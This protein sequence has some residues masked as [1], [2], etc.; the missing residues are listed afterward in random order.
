MVEM[1]A[2]KA[3]YY[4]RREYRPGTQFTVDNEREAAKME[5]TN[6]AQRIP[7]KPKHVDV[8]KPAKVEE[9]DD[10]PKKIGGRGRTY[11]RR[12]MVATDGPTGEEIPL[13]SSLQEPQSEEQ[14]STS[15]EAEPE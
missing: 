5:R 7:D 9:P 8:P 6:K 12:D 14:T 15:S 4:G 3:V 10:N 11:Q 2:K 13:P 1:I